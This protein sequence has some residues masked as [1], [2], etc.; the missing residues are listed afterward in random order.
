MEI[1]NGYFSLNAKPFFMYSGEIHYFRIKKKDWPARLRA[2]KEAGFNSVSTYIPWIWHEPEEGQID[3]TGRTLPERDVLGFIDLAG[4][5]GLTVSAR[6]G[7]ISNAELVNEGLPVWL[8]KGNPD[9]FVTGRRDVGN[10]PMSPSF[11]TCTLFFKRRWPRG[12]APS[13]RRSRPAR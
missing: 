6:V 4:K 11:P 7:P 3:L 8:L 5:M 13:C 10:L 9:I 12:T 1:K 2:L